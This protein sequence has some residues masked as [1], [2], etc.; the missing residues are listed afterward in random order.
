M[1][2]LN[3]I[4]NLISNAKKIYLDDT[5]L[6]IENDHLN[7]KLK[8]SKEESIIMLKSLTQFNVLYTFEYTGTS[9][10]VSFKLPSSVKQLRC[11]KYQKIDLS[12][13]QLE[14]L[15]INNNLTKTVHA[16]SGGI[17]DSDSLEKVIP[18]LRQLII[19]KCSNY[20]YKKIKRLMNNYNSKLQLYVYD[21][22][23]SEI[24]LY[25]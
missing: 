15:T 8:I 24:D 4:N 9:N 25:S 23:D 16:C 19:S 1:D 11:N 12:N 3:K 2:L 22:Y 6:S 18:S 21:I 20:E 13:L 14:I 10:D 17:F 5:L 7:L